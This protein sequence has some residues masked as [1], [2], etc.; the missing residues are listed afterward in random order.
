MGNLQWF[1]FWQEMSSRDG[2]VLLSKIK[3]S[4]MLLEE[5]NNSDFHN[6]IDFS[7]IVVLLLQTRM[8]KEKVILRL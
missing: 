6:K 8:K 1:L 2:K 4:L 7:L 5:E 3:H